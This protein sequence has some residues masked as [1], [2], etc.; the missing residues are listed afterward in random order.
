MPQVRQF[1]RSDRA[2]LSRLVNVHAAGA[3]PGASIPVSTL[4]SDLE[5][6]LGEDVVGPWVVGRS[7]IV[8]I[9]R[10]RLVAAAHLWRYADDHRPSDSYRGTAEIAWLL[11]WPEHLQA[12]RAVRDAALGQ[13]RR[14]GASRWYADGQLP[15]PGVYGV[16]DAWPHVQQLYGEAGFDPTSGQVEIIYAGTLDG[17]PRPGAQP[18]PGVVVR[19]EVG[20]LGTAFDAV[21]GGEVVGSYEVDDD[22]SRGGANLALAG[23]ADECNH[24]VREDLRGR[25]IG[26]WLVAHAAEWLRLGGTTRLLAYGIEGQETDSLTPYYA[27]YG[28]R[29]VNRTVRGWVRDPDRSG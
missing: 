16:S 5:R 14:W 28:L 27:R 4:L 26:T 25:G 6:P 13:L 17:I 19:R 15:A 23:W 12:G 2:Q 20:T 24:W 7:T 18:L 1:V 11:C 29:P 3:S 10:D 9:E 21:L 22:L 8:A